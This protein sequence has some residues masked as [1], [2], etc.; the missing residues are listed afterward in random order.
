M[1]TLIIVHGLSGSGKTR[2][3]DYLRDSLVF[4][5]H[6]FDNYVGRLC[7]DEF[8]WKSVHRQYNHSRDFFKNSLAKETYLMI[9]KLQEDFLEKRKIFY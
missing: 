5:D 9:W 4:A 1:P 7:Q 3:S 6:S 2:I 8:P